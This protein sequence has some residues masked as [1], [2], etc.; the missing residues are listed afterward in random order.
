MIR[1]LHLAAAALLVFSA[2]GAMA[3]HSGSIGTPVGAPQPVA[4]A[5]QQ[6]VPPA[7]PVDPAQPYAPAAGIP[8]PQ[9]VPAPGLEG[10]QPALPAAPA[11]GQPMTPVTVPN[12]QAGAPLETAPAQEDPCAAFTGSYDA[13]AMC[14]DRQ[15]KIQR[16][17]DAKQ[18]RTAPPPAAQAPAPAAEEDPLDKLIERVQD[19]MEKS[20]QKEHEESMKKSYIQRNKS[21]K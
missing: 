8:T 1:L 9:L 18:R 15:K 3:Q 20:R 2:G 19:S 4:P 14:Q 17:H 13:Y 6:P 7:M 5:T 21:G 16:M 12:S 11:A 10:T